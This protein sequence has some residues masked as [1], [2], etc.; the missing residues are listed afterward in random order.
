MMIARYRTAH[1]A[2]L[3]LVVAAGSMMTATHSAAIHNAAAGVV[4]DKSTSFS[5]PVSIAASNDGSLLLIANQDSGDVSVV[6]LDN[7]DVTRSPR[8]AR[9][10]NDIAV[11]PGSSRVLLLDTCAKRL[12]SVNFEG[13]EWHAAQDMPLEIRPTQLATSGGGRLLCVT[14]CWDKAICIVQLSP[15][16]IPIAES[17]KVFP[18]DFNPRHVV[19]LPDARFLV[20]DAFG[21]RLAVIDGN[22]RSKHDAIIATQILFGHHIGGLAI[23]KNGKR[24]LIAHQVLSHVAHTTRDDIHWGSLMQNVV[25]L[26]STDSLAQDFETFDHLRRVIPVGDTGNAAADPAGVSF[27]KDGLV[28]ASSGSNR[29]WVTDSPEGILNDIDVGSCPTDIAI[30]PDGRVAVVN[31][32]DDTVSIVSLTD[33]NT[34]ATYGTA[35]SDLSA[36]QRGERLFFSGVLSHDRWMSCS[37]CHVDGHT[38]DLL[39]DTMGDRAF[40]SPKRIPSLIGTSETGPWGWLGNKSTIQD[41]I[42]QTLKSTMHGGSTADDV[43]ADLSAF[44]ATLT[45]PAIDLPL[46]T[47]PGWQLFERRGCG[48][49]HKLPQLT[50]AT[51]Y[52]IGITDESGH[53]EFN[54]P[55]LRGLRNRSRY[56]HDGRFDSLEQLLRSHPD[57]DA[58][59]LNRADRGVLQNFLLSL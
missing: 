11:S 8:L 35:A 31:Q 52:D 7:D 33:H 2:G 58:A 56:L 23:S 12:V 49:C 47:D 16:G 38:P 20:A 54:P 45:H 13:N 37:S 43:V 39:A 14:S 46:E 19:A 17:A 27:W 30:L 26:I 15:A 50:N 34:D 22:T 28:V 51:T 41:Q 3:L 55:S 32:L 5:R 4:A 29:V 21:G 53:T 48:R 18:L 10:I 36:E 1:I 40:G 44:I 59:P 6:D 42:R 57:P 9:S 24:I 25:S